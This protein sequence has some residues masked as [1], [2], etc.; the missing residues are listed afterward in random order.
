MSAPAIPTR[1][2]AAIRSYRGET[3]FREWAEKCW[4]TLVNHG[5]DLALALGAPRDGKPGL[6]DNTYAAERLLLAAEEAGWITRGA[7]EIRKEQAFFDVNGDVTGK[8]LRKGQKPSN[9]RVYCWVPNHKSES[10]R[11]WLFPHLVAKPEPA[12][13]PP[14]APVVAPVL[15]EKRPMK[16]TVQKKDLLPA[17]ATCAEVAARSAASGAAAVYSC[18]LLEWGRSPGEMTARAAGLHQSVR[19]KIPEASFEGLGSA[20]VH[21]GNLRARVEALTD[22]APITIKIDGS[23]LSLSQGTTRLHLALLPAEDAPAFPQIGEGGVEIDAAALARILTRILPTVGSDATRGSTYGARLASKDGILYAQAFEGMRAAFAT[24]PHA[25]AS[26]DVYVPRPAIEDLR[27]ILDRVGGPVRCAVV[28]PAL[29]VVTDT[30]AYTTQTYA[31]GTPLSL[32]AIPILQGP[33]VGASRAD[34]AR[35]LKVVQAGKPDQD[36]VRLRHVDGGLLLRGQSDQGEIAQEVVA[37]SGQIDNFS[38][39]GPYLAAALAFF[40]SEERIELWQ[41]RAKDPKAGG[42]PGTLTLR[43]PASKDAYIVSPRI[44]DEEDCAPEPASAEAAE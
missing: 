29:H 6:A 3:V 4:H 41:V 12:A 14:P 40:A 7:V 31:E 8:H 11:A 42:I 26:I 21:A 13:A 38:L 17:V 30:L 34:L 36:R 27:R 10:F 35:A 2:E 18:T 9:P 15:Q 33:M 39:A 37:T 44:L 1:L 22:T 5:H 43:A 32:H 19:V 20:L 24:M 28:G 23:R 25:G 16:I